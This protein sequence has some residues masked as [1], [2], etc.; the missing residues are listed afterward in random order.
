[1]LIIVLLRHRIHAVPPADLR[2]I[3]SRPVIPAERGRQY[4]FTPKK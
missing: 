1:L 2:V 3:H 4:Q